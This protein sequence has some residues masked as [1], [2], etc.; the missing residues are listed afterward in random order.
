MASNL[1][2]GFCQSLVYLKNEPIQFNGR[3]Y[4][5]AIYGSEARNLVVRASRQ[6]E[7]TTFVVNT[8]VY[9][10]CK[11]PGTQIL[12]VTPRQEQ[13]RVLA[14]SRLVPI[15]QQSPIIRR[16]L[17]GKSRRQ[18][19]ITNMRFA[20]GS[21]LYIRAA[22]HTGDAVRGI[23]ADWLIVDEVQDIAA[24]D[25]PV[26]QETLSHSKVGRTILMGTP[27]LIENHLEAAFSRSTAN[28][29]TLTCPGCAASVV[30]DENCLGLHGIVCRHC[31]CA[32]DAG[33]GRWVPR[34]P[35]STWGDGYWIN[36]LMVP[37]MNYDE[38][39]DRQRIYDLAKFKNEVL[40]LST[41]LG[42]HVVTRA[43]LEA[44]CSSRP[45]AKGIADIPGATPS[46][47]IAGIDWGGGGQS[48][49]VVVIGSMRHDFVFEVGALHRFRADE[50]TG[51]L[52]DCIVEICQA[53]GVRLIAADGGGNGHVYNRLLLERLK[54]DF[55]MYAILYSAA[56]QE[57]R[58]DGILWKWTVHRTATI[59][60]LFSRVKNRSIVFPRVDECGSFLDE[61]ACELA[62]F[63]EANR[64]IRYTHPATMQ[65][66]ALHA[67]NYA[68][69]MGIRYFHLN[70][71]LSD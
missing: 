67:T 18:S 68:L 14:R 47:V 63:D 57:P 40:G 59:G 64:T 27:K 37:W 17:V 53:F 28:E 25:L 56:S 6:V 58:Q 66:D 13:A 8:I 48:R 36:H 12:L 55:D 41:T 52:L 31:Q 50:D 21:E 60:A 15:V 23:S 54:Y 32:V 71:G 33:T 61:F 26:L 46:S 45:M 43:E 29:W 44:C 7:K 9:E 70:A 11:N 10:L 19:P 49:T 22:Y 62:T 30:L 5:A 38:I 2:L 24:G 39:L 1:K 69:L 3:P 42:E 16:A 35:E 51:Q 65:D 20:N 34:N 4:L